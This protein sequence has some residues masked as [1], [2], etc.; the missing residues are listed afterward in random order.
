MGQYVIRFIEEANKQVDITFGS[1]V[2]KCSGIED[3]DDGWPKFP[4]VDG[5]A[6]S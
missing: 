4:Q 1:H 5:V 3:C 2:F 6:N